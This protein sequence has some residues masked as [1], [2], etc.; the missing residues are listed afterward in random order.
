MKKLFALLAVAFIGLVGAFAFDVATVRGTWLDERY[1]AHWTF[2]GDGT[3]VLSYAST[4]EVI[5]VFDDSNVEN[6]RV[7][8]DNDNSGQKGAGLTVQFSCPQTHRKYK[9]FKAASFDSNIDIDFD[10]DWTDLN[11][12]STFQF[13]KGAAE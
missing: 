3:I 13:V 10:P 1:D 9:F 2:K 11:Y 12:R 5:F 8:V 6:F 7:G 4:G